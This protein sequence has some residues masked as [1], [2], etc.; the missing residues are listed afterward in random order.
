MK[1]SSKIAIGLAGALVVALA[2]G[3][4]ALA[5]GHGHDAFVKRRITRH[6][7][8]AL[9]AVAANGAQRNA[10]YAARDHV[11]ATLEESHKAERGDF[12]E[13][14]KLW[15]ADRL[16][17]GQLATLRAR[18]QAAAKRAGDAVVQAL[19]D[20]HDA[21]T[22][23]QRRKLGDYLRAHRP[24]FDR[25]NVEAMK[26]FAHHMVSE[27]VDDLLD[28]IKA[29]P[30]QRDK[31][32]AAVERAFASVTAQ[33]G[34][35]AAQLDQAVTLFTADRID[36]AKVAALQAERQARM[37]SVGDAIVQALSEVHDTLDA[38]QRKAVANYIR[39][40]HRRHG[41]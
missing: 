15:E 13:A 35:H 7:D 18:H 5:S 19:S 28:E 31:I 16:D 33:L 2:A 26:P 11:F 23:E 10:V 29:R 34:D 39:A 8:Q 27:R 20:A 25:H 38:G 6:I 30:D 36:N 17:A 32:H 37:Q 41:G 14:L 3:S 21:L 40:H 1:R 22:A 24:P 4:A 9:D 12:E